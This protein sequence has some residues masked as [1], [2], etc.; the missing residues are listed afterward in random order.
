MG[1]FTG[2]SIPRSLLVSRC[3]RV[4]IALLSEKEFGPTGRG[5]WCGNDEQ[6]DPGS[7]DALGEKGQN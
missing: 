7:A 3:H 5:Y 1:S 2:A 4:G 6:K